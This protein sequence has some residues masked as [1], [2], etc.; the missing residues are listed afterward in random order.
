MTPDTSSLPIIGITTYGRNVEN[1]FALPA[2]YVDSVRRA[3]GIPVLLPPGEVA[4]A[5]L[6]DQINGLILAGGGDLDPRHYDGEA[7]KTFYMLDQERD[8][9]ELAGA[10]RG[11]IL[12]RP[13]K[14]DDRIVGALA[15]PKKGTF[16]AITPEGDARTIE[17]MSV[18]AGKR[19]GKGQK[20]V[21][22]GGVAGLRYVEEKE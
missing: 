8:V 3:G 20:V 4:F 7:H 10:G 18:P 14:G 1:K 5:R 6:L 9:T 11:V 22:R 13:D 15:V 17:A 19:A 12:M 16:L 2:E 21:K